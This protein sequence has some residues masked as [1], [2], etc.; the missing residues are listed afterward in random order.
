ML[1]LDKSSEFRVIDAKDHAE[2]DQ[3]EQ[4][5]AMGYTVLHPT[6]RNA[7][8]FGKIAAF[9]DAMAELAKSHD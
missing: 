1:T 9:R 6:V 3:H 2:S 7:D 4:L 5:R 8:T